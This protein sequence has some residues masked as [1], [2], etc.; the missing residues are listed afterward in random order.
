MS[1]GEGKRGAF[2]FVRWKASLWKV[3]EGEVENGMT[4]GS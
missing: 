2:S 1:G 3:K 4:R